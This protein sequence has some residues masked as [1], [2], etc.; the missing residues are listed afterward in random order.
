M[1]LLRGQLPHASPQQLQNRRPPFSP[2]AAPDG[3]GML[4]PPPRC[5]AGVSFLP[6]ATPRPSWGASEGRT[7][8]LKPCDCAKFRLQECVLQRRTPGGQERL[9]QRR[10]RTVCK[11]TIVPP[12]ACA[13]GVRWRRGPTLRRVRSKPGRAAA[14]RP[15]KSKP[16]ATRRAAPRSRR[17]GRG[18]MAFSN[19]FAALVP[20]ISTTELLLLKPPPR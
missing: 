19:R 14:T 15:R 9:A 7:D 11:A 13:H 8:R 12:A 4:P 5:G 6:V 18:Q 16:D 2:N 20:A 10:E 17:R 1:A 3:G